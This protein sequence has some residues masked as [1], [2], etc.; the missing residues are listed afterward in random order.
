MIK[1]ILKAFDKQDDIILDSLQTQIGDFPNIAWYPS[2]GLDFR[3]LMEVNRTQIEPDIFFHTDYSSN[4]VKFERGEV[5][6]DQWTN[7][8]IKGITELKFIKKINYRINPDFVDFPEHAYSR[9][10]IFLLDVQ[11]QSGFYGQINKPVIYFFMENINF[12]D[13]VL[14]K[15]NIKLSHFIKV[16]EGCGM[17]G[18]RKSISLAYAFLGELKVKHILVDNQ[19]H[20]DKELINTISRKHNLNP[21]K[22]ELKNPSQMRYITDWSGFRVKVHDVKLM[23]ANSLSSEDLDAILDKIRRY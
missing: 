17:G 13:E 15:N 10:K 21:I 2:A 14:L 20:T 18:N 11:I 16:R 6:N 12:L 9:P 3:D 4:W 22:Y 7:V 23:P 8:Y 1:N 5:F 19:E